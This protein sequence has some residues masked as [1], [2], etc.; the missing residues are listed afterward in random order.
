[1]NYEFSSAY[2]LLAP[3]NTPASAVTILNQ[4]IVRALAAEDAQ[5]RLKEECVDPV[6]STPQYLKN[7]LVE[8]IAKYSK[9]VRATGMKVE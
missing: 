1:M 7:Y 9:I 2:G 8:Q 5:T 4:G 3:R 6:G